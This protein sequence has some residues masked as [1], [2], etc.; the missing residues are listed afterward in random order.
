M[1]GTDM[2][3]AADTVLYIPIEKWAAQYI[4]LDTIVQVD[5]SSALKETATGQTIWEHRQIAQYQASPGGGG[6]VI[7]AVAAAIAK[8]K[9]AGTAP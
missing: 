3:H 4:V 5:I 2:V 7:K 8:A 9:D 6:L 1:S